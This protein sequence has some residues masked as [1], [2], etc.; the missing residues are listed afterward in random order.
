MGAGGEKNRLGLVG[1]RPRRKIARGS[2]PP[3]TCAGD[4][5]GRNRPRWRGG[6]CS[7]TRE[8][9]CGEVHGGGGVD[10]NPG[11]HGLG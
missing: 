2:P 10:T 1:G 7:Y 3:H 11:R 8:C 6:R 5:R 9:H 4:V